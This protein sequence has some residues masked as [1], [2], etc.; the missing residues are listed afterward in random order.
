MMG[1]LTSGLDCVAA[2]GDETGMEDEPNDG[3]RR[4]ASFGL[5]NS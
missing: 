1:A 5:A 2:G 4:A 3:E